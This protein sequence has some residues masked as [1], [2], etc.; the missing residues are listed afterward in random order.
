MRVISAIGVGVAEHIGHMR[1]RD[2][3]GALGEELLE[4]LERERPSSSTLDPFQ[5]RA[6][7]LAQEMPGDDVGMMLHHGQDDLVALADM[8]ETERGGDEIDRLRRAARKDDFVGGAGIEEA[9]HVSRAPSKASV[10]ALA[11]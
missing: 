4:F 10:A 8:R 9:P 11:R 5:D 1:D 3:L 6:L 2:D 7:A